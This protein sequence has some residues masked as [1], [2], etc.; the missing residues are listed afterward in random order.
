MKGAVPVNDEK[1]RLL[2]PA[3]GV[4]KGEIARFQKLQIGER[5]KLIKP[6]KTKSKLPVPSR[7][8]EKNDR[9]V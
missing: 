6:N 9:S 1:R 8:S 3:K 4:G 2:S 5:F 7:K